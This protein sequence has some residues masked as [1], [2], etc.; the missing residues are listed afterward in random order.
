MDLTQSSLQNFSLPATMRLK[1][2]KLFDQL[3]EK[4]KRHWASPFEA[5]AMEI[6]FDINYPLQVAFVAPKRKLKKAS[7]R[8]RMKRLMRESFRL[9]KNELLNACLVRQKGVVVLFI[10]Q[11]NNPV[12]YLKTQ[13][14]IKLLLQRLTTE[15]AQTAG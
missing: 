12:D 3:F 14:K 13:E 15:H 9:N 4:G 8:N 11:C 5:I 10:S 6:P 7:D 1:S 2:K